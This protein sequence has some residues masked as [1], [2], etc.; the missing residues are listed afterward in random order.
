[1]DV[2]YHCRPKDV[3]LSVHEAGFCDQ[4]NHQMCRSSEGGAKLCMVISASYDAEIAQRNSE[5]SKSPRRP[6]DWITAD[7]TAQSLRNLRMAKGE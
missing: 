3:D 2:K 1:M 5:K 7:T 4:Y 6:G